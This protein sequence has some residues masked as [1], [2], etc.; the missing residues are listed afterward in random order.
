MAIQKDVDPRGFLLND[1]D[2][3][4][5]HLGE[6]TFADAIAE[7][8]HQVESPITIG[9]FA[10]WGSGKSFLLRHLES[11]LKRYQRQS[12]VDEKKKK[13]YPEDGK[14]KCS[15]ILSAMIWLFCI[16][17]AFFFILFT[18]L[19]A[20]KPELVATILGIENLLSR[21]YETVTTP[22]VN[23]TTA[24]PA[25][26][27]PPH[28]LQTLKII[29]LVLIPIETSIVF[30]VACCG[31]SWLSFHYYG[32]C[33]LLTYGAFTKLPVRKT[34]TD[35]V[36]DPGQ[37]PAHVLK[38][39]RPED[40]RLVMAASESE[41]FSRRYIFVDFKAWEY[42]GSDTLW[43]GIITNITDAI[44][45]EFGIITARMFRMLTIE[46]I[47]KNVLETGNRILYV[48]LGNGSN[49]DEVLDM[50]K[51]YGVVEDCVRIAGRPGQK[52]WKVTYS[53]EGELRVA[54]E[55]LKIEGLE[56]TDVDPTVGA[57]T[58]P[59]YRR[60]KQGWES[61][62]KLLKK[63]DDVELKTFKTNSENKENDR[64]IIERFTLPP[65][66]CCC[67]RFCSH[68]LKYPIKLCGLPRL[69]WW[70]LIVVCS[71]LIPVT[72]YIM[73]DY[74]QLDVYRTFRI[75]PVM[76]QILL[77]MPAGI[78]VISVVFRFIWAMCHSQRKRINEALDGT[79][80]KMAEQLGFMN[81]V[82]TE[83][84]VITKL[85]QCARFTHQKDYKIVITID[86][87]DRVPLKKVQAVL[88]AVSILLS[89]KSAPF[90][91]LIAVDP[92]I[93]VKCIEEGMGEVLKQAKVTGHEYLK[94]IIN[95]PICLPEISDC[96]KKRF[97]AG[98]ID[99][100]DRTISYRIEDERAKKRAVGFRNGNI[101]AVD[102]AEPIDTTDN[103]IQTNEDQI[104]SNPDIIIHDVKN[105]SNPTDH[106]AY[107]ISAVASIRGVDAR[108]RGV[109]C[110]P[111]VEL[112]HKSFLFHCRNFIFNDEDLHKHL[113]GNPRN[114]KRLFNVI[115]LTARIMNC[116][117]K[118]E[119]R[120][121]FIHSHINDNT[122]NGPFL[123]DNRLVRTQQGAEDL[124]R[125]IVLADQWPYRTS[126][127]LQVI[128]DADQRGSAGIEQEKI[129][130][131][132]TIFEIFQN[133]VQNEYEKGE[134]LLS[135]DGDP[136][137]F[138]SY[139]Q[140]LGDCGFTK[141]RIQ[142][143]ERYTVNLDYSLRHTIAFYRD[144]SCMN[145]NESKTPV[146]PDDDNEKENK[147]AAT[148]NATKVVVEARPEDPQVAETSFLRLDKQSDDR[149]LSL[150]AMLE[151]C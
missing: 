15:T 43:A 62:R 101:T 130:D 36:E 78:A 50:M 82:K 142:R 95:L 144:L 8:I 141:S 99:Q 35:I 47:P 60:N 70:I 102:S 52:Y 132:W 42:A 1:Y 46:E 106:S 30:L 11:I 76:G 86:D 21:N 105:C 120:T 114:I 126:Y 13:R 131:D 40:R 64:D 34:N 74:L 61:K 37:E 49:I 29:G 110:E 134:S 55:C 89:D 93:V 53:S 143:L 54:K 123:D 81:K 4:V 7:S 22:A 135:L 84:E 109:P 39:I 23:S 90:I 116:F 56:A 17:A 87:L 32:S 107:I 122:H 79:K 147:N 133:K 92:R 88:E 2:I 91:C 121:R 66:T 44:E 129:P 124:V 151:H 148:K 100:A 58:P 117:H 113:Q 96:D 149:R 85:I 20:A 38:H 57:S 137:I 14:V 97:I 5:D 75:V 6:S 104:D 139:I 118:K 31:K 69:V 98:L 103:Y 65:K 10:K 150:P 145:P 25:E 127:I 63:R 140:L 19:S 73:A 119:K 12:I 108:R 146:Q 27:V 83:V 125:W 138:Y 112:D 128:E 16:L 33:R 45:A 80:T 18:V 48:K 94:K 3:G 51:Q 9:L 41:V 26:V 68:F 59:N 67:N 72:A 24:N 115:S 136:D 111:I 71:I 28:Y 77:W